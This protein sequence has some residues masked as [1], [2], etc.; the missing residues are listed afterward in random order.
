VVSLLTIDSTSLWNPAGEVAVRN[1][2]YIAT[3]TQKERRHVAGM[4]STQN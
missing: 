2:E 3:W 4:K 1:K